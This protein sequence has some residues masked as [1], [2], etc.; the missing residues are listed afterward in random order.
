MAVASQRRWYWMSRV[1]RIVARTLPRGLDVG[2]S[3]E[4]T[5][6]TFGL[7]AYLL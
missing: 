3:S 2:L 1:D 4:G 5:R 7:L 6:L